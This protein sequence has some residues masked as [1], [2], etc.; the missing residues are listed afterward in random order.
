MTGR[1]RELIK[2]S[3]KQ[4]LDGSLWDLARDGSR[5]ALAQNMQ[6]GQRRIQILSLSGAE[7]REVVTKGEIPMMSLAWANDGRGF[8]V[9]SSDGALLFVDMDGRADVLWKGERAFFGLGP[10][11]LPSPDG[12]RV[13]MLSWTLDSNVWMIENF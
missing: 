9:G 1:G 3:L 5:L 7:A 6:G 10:R 13:A 4:P 8:F 12:R 11:G 2:L